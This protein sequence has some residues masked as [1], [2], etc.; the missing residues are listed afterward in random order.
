VS[1]VGGGPEKTILN[2][3]RFVDPARYRM[4]C[5]YMRC[6]ADAGFAEL[7]R[8]ARRW[9]A[10]LVAVDDRGPLDWR[11]AARL[12]ELCRR[13]DVRIW[14]GHDYKSNLLG[15]LARRRHPMRLVTTVHGWVKHTWKTPLYYAIDRLALRGYERVVCVS[16]DLYRACRRLGIPEERLRHV[17]NAIDTAEF[18]RRGERAAAKAERGT[19]P[20]RLVIGAVGRLSAEKAFDALVRAF[21]ALAGE[22]GVEAE[23]WIAG[24]GEERERL[25]RLAAELGVGA[26]VRLL[27]FCSEPRRLYEAMDVYCVSSLREGLP[28]SLLEAMAFEVA[29][30]ATRVAGIPRLVRD[31]EN[32]LLIE[33]GSVAGLKAGLRALLGEPALRAR[34]GAEAR[35]TIEREHDF[36][37]RMERM[38]A[39]Y[40][41]LLAGPAVR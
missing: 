37:R 36:A 28:N 2:S 7:E 6:P 29:V 26:R 33:P 18:R 15:L 8:R 23:L 16:E 5:A 20:A 24:E 22:G 34:L 17:P 21:A 30:L 14:H 41:E 10:P 25:E 31:G 27:G 13:E 11:V 35:A 19:D 39:I 38:V 12:A 4:L 1:G 3:P 32:G 40:D 9:Q